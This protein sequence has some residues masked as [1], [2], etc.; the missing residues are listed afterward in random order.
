MKFKSIFLF[1][2]MK[3]NLIRRNEN[4]FTVLLYTNVI[5]ITYSYYFPIA[6]LSTRI[7]IEYYNR[8]FDVF[9]F[10]VLV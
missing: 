5:L 6:F 10:L 8:L 1:R 2:K 9:T 7:S 4:I 3:E